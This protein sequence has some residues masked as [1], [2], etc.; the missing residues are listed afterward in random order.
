MDRPIMKKIRMIQRSAPSRLALCSHLSIIQKTRAVN[1]EER[2]YT[3]PSTALNQ[4]E[5]ENV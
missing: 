4:N 3:S 2:A 5:S 1:R